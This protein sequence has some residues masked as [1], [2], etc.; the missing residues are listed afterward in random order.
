MCKAEARGWGKE[1]SDGVGEKGL[2]RSL[3]CNML[4]VNEILRN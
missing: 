4:E 1:V 3:A 2:G